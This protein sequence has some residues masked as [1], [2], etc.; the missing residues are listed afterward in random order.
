MPHSGR[1]ASE[2]YAYARKDYIANNFRLVNRTSNNTY[3]INRN[4]LINNS[5]R[6]GYASTYYTG[7]NYHFYFTLYNQ[8]YYGVGARFWQRRYY[9]DGLDFYF[10]WNPA[11]YIL[12][13]W[14]NTGIRYFEP[15]FAFSFTFNHG[16]ERGYIEGFRQGTWDWNNYYSYRGWLGR[17]SGYHSYWGPWNEY[18]DGYEQGFRQ[19]YY[20]GYCGF[21][22]GY[23]NFGFGD[24]GNYPVI[25]DY[26]YD[27][28]ETVGYPSNDNRYYED[29]YYD[30]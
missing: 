13:G 9:G 25:Y 27:Y 16:Y 12:Y 6:W 2:R 26:D 3:V 7:R 21:S 14:W 4:Y 28:Y 23:M 11:N 20:A 1:S 18:V 30:Y 29:S 19:G 24:F 8:N 17:Y 22:Y 5:G 15:C 10:G